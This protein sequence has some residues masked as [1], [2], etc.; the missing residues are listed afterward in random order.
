MGIKKVDE[1]WQLFGKETWDKWH[2]RLQFIEWGNESC[3]HGNGR[4]ISPAVW[5]SRAGARAGHSP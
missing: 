2:R 4:R 5:G 3:K 1:Q